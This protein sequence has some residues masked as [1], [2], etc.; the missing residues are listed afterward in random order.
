MIQPYY[1]EE[2]I[3]IYNGNCKEILSELPDDYV[4]FS[5]PPYNVGYQYDTYNDRLPE[6][7]YRDLLRTTLRTPSIV[8]HYPERICEIAMLLNEIPTRI[9]SWVYNTNM[10]RQHRNIAWFGITP[11]FTKDEQPYKNLED[12]RIQERMAEG[13]TARLYDWWEINIVKNVSC[14]K[15]DHPCQIPLEVMLHVLKITPDDVT[16]VDPFMG[17]GTTL[18]AAKQLG[19]KAIGIEI[20]KKYCDIAVKRL[21]RGREIFLF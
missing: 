1:E 14:E 11:D 21:K 4:V 3:I 8:L 19:R 13:K 20:D 5:D 18:V 16:I 9:V 15:T 10:L 12:K 2:N 6:Y 7:E 17:S